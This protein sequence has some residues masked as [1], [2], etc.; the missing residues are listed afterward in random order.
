MGCS[1]Y[2]YELPVR[3]PVPRSR[4]RPPPASTRVFLARPPRDFAFLP[5]CRKEGFHFQEE[6][7]VR[8]LTPCL[9]SPPR[10]RCAEGGSRG[11][12]EWSEAPARASGVSSWLSGALPGARPLS[13]NVL[14]PHPQPPRFL[15]RGAGWMAGPQLLSVPKGRGRQPGSRGRGPGGR[16]ASY[17][18]SRGQERQR[19]PSP[20][21]RSLSLRPE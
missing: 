18:D 2:G 4:R 11:R 8:K 13:Q 19:D 7:N 5:R 17:P 12:E 6:N 16:R 20:P 21:D 9:P 10:G 14:L 3:R 1:R 15:G